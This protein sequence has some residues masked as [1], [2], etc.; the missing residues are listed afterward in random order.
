MWSSLLPGVCVIGLVVTW[1]YYARK[2]Q[3]DVDYNPIWLKVGA[4]GMLLLILSQTL[5]GSFIYS[6]VPLVVLGMLWTQ[7]LT[8]SVVMEMALRICLSGVLIYMVATTFSMEELLGIVSTA[9]FLL[10]LGLLWAGPLVG[11]IGG[12]AIDSVMGG[13]QEVEA[14]PLYSIAETKWHRSD[15]E[16]AI[17]EIDSELEKFPGDYDGQVMKATIQLEA[18]RDFNAAQSTLLEVIQQPHHEPGQIARAMNML[19]DWQL[20]HLDNK[21]IARGTLEAIVKRFPNTGIEL[22]TAQ[23]LAR[24]DFLLDYDDKRDTGEVVSD[25]LKQLEKHPLDNDTREKLARVYFNRYDKPDL[26][27]QEMAKLFENTFQ[28]PRDIV[29]WLNRMADWHLRKDNPKGAR[30]CLQQIMARFPQLPSCEAA[31]QRLTLIKEK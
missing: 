3:E 31:Q 14:K 25:C 2:T 22:M 13:G 17:A 5:G 27:W 24:M 28:Q 26:A 11:W 29:R 4:S 19:A 30:E 18:L 10:L 8:D 20:K 9:I 21:E 1:I 6:F 12:G 23:R 16:G 7:R 15:P